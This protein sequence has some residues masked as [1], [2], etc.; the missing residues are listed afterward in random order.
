MFWRLKIQS[1]KECWQVYGLV[2]TS[3]NKK[4]SVRLRRSRTQDIFCLEIVVDVVD[5]IGM[6]FM[7]KDM[8]NMDVKAQSKVLKIVARPTVELDGHNRS[9]NSTLP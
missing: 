7:G 5:A 1:I 9:F 6:K 3:R 8:G 2:R 4:C